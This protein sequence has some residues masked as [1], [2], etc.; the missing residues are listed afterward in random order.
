MPTLQANGITLNY[1][2]SG[3]GEPLLLI[4][5]LAAD[6]A[7]YAFQVADYAKHFRC[8]SVDPRG[9]GLSDKPEGTYTTELLADDIAAL[10]Q[11]L[12]LRSAHVAGLSLGAAIG[13]WL[14]AKYPDRVKTLSLHSAWPKSDQFLRTVV[15]GW[16]V[17]AR[18]LG[19]V[20][21]MIVTGIFPW[22][23]TPDFYSGNPDYI[24][25]LADFVRGRPVQSVE[26]F[27]RQSAAVQSHDA[28]SQLDRIACPTLVT[29]GGQ[30]IVTS[31]RFADALTA[32]IKDAELVVFEDC[33][34]APLYQNVAAFNAQTLAFLQQHAG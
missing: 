6:Q 10:M 30:D 33:S 3:E 8:I 9:A 23:F 21:D 26:A 24:S 18:G 17:I 28:Q 15:D 22:C 1:E 32:G 12:G 13:I 29:F 2:T 31:T 19:N 7:C 5:Y 34:H 27:L 25:S 11:A 4:P 20:P 14:A 16:R